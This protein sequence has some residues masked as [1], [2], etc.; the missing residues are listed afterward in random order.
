MADPRPLKLAALDDA[1][2]A[3][4]SA[5][6]QDAVF[7]TGDVLWSPSEARFIV[8]MNRFA[9]EQAPVQGGW[10]RRGGSNERHRAVLQFDRVRRVRSHGIP[11]GDKEQV[12]AL[13]AVLFAEDEA[14]G[15]T[16]SLVCAGE[17]EIRLEVE[18]VEARLTDLGAAWAATSRPKH[19][20][21]G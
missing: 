11:R 2:L 7:K 19:P 3:V 14:P 15:G 20:G 12:V 17:A 21:A 4:I 6:V 16:I 8:P 10:T 1:D 18:C 5:H 9:W 13:L